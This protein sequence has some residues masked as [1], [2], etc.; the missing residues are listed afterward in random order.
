MAKPLRAGG[1]I[2]G[3]CTKCK[4]VLNHRI[5]AMNGAIPARVECST[6]T[7]HH[8]FRARAPGDKAPAGAS[9]SSRASAAPR[10]TRGPTKAQ[11]VLI[12]RERSWEKAV[13]GKAVSDFRPYRVSEVF[14]EGE[15]VRHSKFGD[16]VVLRL[17]EG[18]KVEVLFKD[19]SR[20]LAHGLTD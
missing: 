19:D 7:S 13:N 18:R 17:L 14:E 20:T 3:W 15:L 4:L 12:D 16:G 2:D 9:T 5:I 8:N 11:K 6:C 10:S 1:E